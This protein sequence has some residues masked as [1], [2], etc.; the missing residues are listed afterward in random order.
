MKALRYKD[1]SDLM[2]VIEL[3]QTQKLSPGVFLSTH[4]VSVH[5]EYPVLFIKNIRSTSSRKWS[6]Q[7]RVILNT[8]P[9]YWK[10]LTYILFLV[11]CHSLDYHTLYYD[12][13]Q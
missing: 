6:V 8:A 10:F 9:I 12:V 2:K 13:I 1:I 5:C 7:I 11:Y 4:I 3:I